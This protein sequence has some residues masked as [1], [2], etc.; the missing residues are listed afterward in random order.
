[1]QKLPLHERKKTKKIADARETAATIPTVL[2]IEP[3]PV[4][5]APRTIPPQVQNVTVA[6]GV[7]KH[8]RYHPYHCP[9]NTLGTESYVGF[10][11]HSE[12]LILQYLIPSIFVFKE[13]K[14]TR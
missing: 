10:H 9:L 7:R 8:T 12:P 14:M 1:M 11:A 5:A 2:R 6:I 13:I 4:E 3:V